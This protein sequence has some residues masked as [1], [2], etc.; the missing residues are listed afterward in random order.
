L[1]VKKLGEEGYNFAALGFSLSYKSTV[2]RSKEVMPK[3]AF[4]KDGE[5]KFLES[6]ILWMDVRAPRFWW[7]EADTYRIATK[8]SESTMH[9]LAKKH[10]V[11][12]DFEHP[13]DWNYLIVLNKEID[14]FKTK[15]IPIDKLKN[16][17]P[18]GYLQRRIWCMSYK[19]FRHI[20]NQRLGHRLPQWKV[21]YSSVLETLEHPEFIVNPQQEKNE[22][23][24][25]LRWSKYWKNKFYR[26]GKIK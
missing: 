25:H 14:S 5:D 21:F 11:Q 17:L 13:I 26:I 12:N 2:E 20:Y 19:E 3:Y 4:G 23:N 1:E 18:D 6:I 22:I 16:D 9:C 10:L 7:S 24:Y 15:E 8:Q